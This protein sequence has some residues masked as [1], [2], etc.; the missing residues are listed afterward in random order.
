[1]T[2]AL[3]LSIRQPWAWA[4]LYAGKRIE[5]RTWYTSYRG[6]VLIHAGL[7][8]D[9]GALD[10]LEDVIRAVAE[11]RAPAYRGALVGR[12]TIVDCVRPDQVAPEQDGWAMGPW[13][14]VLDDVRPLAKPVALKGALGFFKI[15]PRD[16]MRIAAEERAK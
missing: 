2:C 7:T 8:V 12:A 9:Y 11:P 4:I 5:N 16:E 13:C 6:Y 3:A 10:D 14:F 1:M 15:N